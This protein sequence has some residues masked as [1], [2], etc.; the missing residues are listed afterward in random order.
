MQ[1]RRE[2]KN[3]FFVFGG[4]LILQFIPHAKAQSR[5]A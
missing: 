4:S 3:D 5:K 2:V 1:L